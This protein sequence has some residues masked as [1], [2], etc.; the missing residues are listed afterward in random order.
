MR[1]QHR[2]SATCSILLACILLFSACGAA[3]ADGKFAPGTYASC[4]KGFGGDVTV[5]VTG[6]YST[7]VS[8]GSDTELSSDTIDR[9]EFDSRFGTSTAWTMA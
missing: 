7:S 8:A 5:T 4:S 3:V 1:T 9:S 6:S 2:I